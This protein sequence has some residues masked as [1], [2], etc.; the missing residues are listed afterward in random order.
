MAISRKLEYYLNEQHISYHTIP[1]FYSNSSVGTAVATSIPPQNIAKAVLLVD[2]D[3]H[4]LMAVLPA[5]KKINLLSINNTLH[6]SFE[7]LNEEEVFKLFTDCKQGAVPPV[8]AAFNM[9]M[10]CD[11]SLDLLESIYIEAGDHET[12]LCINHQDYG[13]IMENSQ[14]IKLCKTHMH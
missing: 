7:L 1:H 11:E 8:G 3:G 5:D 10:V 13:H 4:R 9:S 2:H 12:L 14:H 6:A